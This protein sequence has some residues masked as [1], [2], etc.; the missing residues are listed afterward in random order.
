MEFRLLGWPADGVVLR[1]DHREYAYAGKFV[2]SSTGKA[3]ALDRDGIDDGRDGDERGGRPGDE[4]DDR[5]GEDGAGEFRLPEDPK[6]EFVAPAGAVAF[7]ED[8]TDP[9]ALWLRYVTVRGDRRGEGI[10]PRLCAFVVGRAAER[11]Y[12]RVRI[13]VNNAYSY[14]ALHK[15]GFAWTGRGTGI[16][17]L[18]L[19][20]PADRPAVVDPDAYGEGLA[21]IAAREDVGDDERAFA[22]RKRDRGPPTVEGASG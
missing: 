21:T 18:V 11:G 7:N 17:E 10:G 2:M 4:S 19:E 12:E 13:A 6:R 1:L 14:E 22:R 15:V 8:R 9:G 5:H 20:R 3:V 16:A